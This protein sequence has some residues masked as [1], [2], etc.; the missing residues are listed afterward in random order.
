VTVQTTIDATGWL[1]NHLEGD[2]AD[3]DLA[4][5]MLQAFAEA[6]M[7]AEASMQCQAGYGELGVVVG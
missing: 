7:S 3:T 4:R 2:H 1:R 5:S 6:L